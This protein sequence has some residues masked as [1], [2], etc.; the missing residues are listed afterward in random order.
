[1]NTHTSASAH[2]PRRLAAALLACTWL[3][4]APLAM[5][6]GGTNP[7]GLAQQIHESDIAICNSGGLSAPAREACVR[8][9]G[10][11]LDRS[12]GIVPPDVP[13]T[14]QDGRATVI[15]PEGTPAPPTSSEAVPSRDGRANVIPAR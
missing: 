3:L 7:A 13:L 8:E 6:Q 10:I 2:G 1:M 5:A 11:R 14:T 12:R 4:S 15:T 9:A